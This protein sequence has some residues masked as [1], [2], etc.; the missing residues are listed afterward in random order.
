MALQSDIENPNADEKLHVEFYEY[1][2]PDIPHRGRPFVRIMV[3][4]DKTNV[5]D[6]PVRDSDKQRFPRQWL[7]F[8]VKG[9]EG[10]EAIGTDLA[11]WHKSRPEEISRNQL[12]ELR[13]LKFQT[14]EQVATATDGQLQRVGMGG[15]GLRENARRF[16]DSRRR[17]QS[18]AETELLKQQIEELTKTVSALTA[19]K[20][21]GR[22][23]KSALS[24]QE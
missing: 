12:D 22:P 6:R 17:S 18:S 14:V 7:A 23:P 9:A 15:I 1:Q 19:A 4:G 11:E 16:L 8:Q 3:P 20:K 24:P 21:P 2:G 13:I 5:V 10:L